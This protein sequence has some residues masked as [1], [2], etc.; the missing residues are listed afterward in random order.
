MESRTYRLL[1][2]LRVKE[3]LG[4][5]ALS[6]PGE[7]ACR[8]LEPYQDPIGL[9]RETEL[10]H[11]AL[12]CTREIQNS[13]VPFPELEGLFAL[14][15]A[16][17]VIEE[18]GFWALQVVLQ[19]ALQVNKA[20]TALDPIRNPRLVSFF[21]E[22]AWP[23]KTMQGVNR[24]LSPDGV[25]K[26][27][28][29]PELLRIRQELRRIQTQCTKKIDAYLF[30]GNQI[31]YLQD[32]YLTISSDR[33]V[34]AVKTNF[35][36]K[37]QGIVHDYSQTGETCYVEPLP[38]VELN[39]RLQEIKQEERQARY[40]VLTYL[41]SLFGQEREAVRSTYLRLVELDVLQAKLA[42]AREFEGRDL[43]PG[44]AEVR[45]IKARHPLLYWDSTDTRPLNIEFN[46][47]QQGLIISGGNSGGK[48]VALKTLGLIGLMA[49]SALPVPVEEGSSLPFWKEIHPFFGDEQ[50]LDENLSTF[51]AQI[52]HLRSAWPGL[53]PES[54]VLLDEF[55]AGTDPSQGAALAQAVLDHLLEKG[56]WF[57]AATHFPA[58]KAY[59]LG[60]PKVRA[61]SVLF[62]PRTKHPLYTIAYD[63]V[64]QSQ[65]LDV[66]REQGLPG[67]VIKQAEEYLL[68]DGE[69][70]ERLINRLNRLAVE[71]EKELAE[72]SASKQ[73]LALEQQKWRDEKDRE[74]KA[75]IREA[76][77]AART[78]LKEWREQ[79]TGRKQALRDLDSLKKELRQEMPPRGDRANGAAEDWSRLHIGSRVTYQ[80]W[81]KSGSIEEK[82]EKKQRLK[83]NLGGIS[84]WASPEE[85]F[86]AEKKPASSGGAYYRHGQQTPGY[87]LDLRGQRAEEA[88]VNVNRFLDQAV[89]QGRNEFE[90]IHGKGSGVLRQVVR[91]I[92]KRHKLVTGFFPA[93]ENRGGEGATLVQ[94]DFESGDN[95]SQ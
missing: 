54:L 40:R 90:I 70:S 74:L 69:D 64:G 49:L 11:Q 21:A 17:R 88:E 72:L 87:S 42:M 71:R 46:P 31:Q 10:L 8:E 34:L 30:Q 50:S 15:D 29:S 53:G 52:E 61:A 32:N 24:C 73:K 60:N 59:G 6:I 51:T 38:L 68:L 91:D 33:Y 56:V 77:S 81:Q 5:L 63:Q 85:L 78:I 82:D 9:H 84:I 58:L 44:G 1:D 94:L 67:E 20:L 13:L 4:G 65:A 36:G 76:E 66:A 16:G 48:T 37:I 3:H 39:N 22:H 26:D 7:K 28:S 25:I 83:V 35:K 79:R 92:L 19:Q 57:M 93:P 86:A 41:S 43:Q 62:D 55:G 95:A 14:L 45:L 27:E 89:L 47:E 18:D 2:F 23:D 75:L 80:P 12:D